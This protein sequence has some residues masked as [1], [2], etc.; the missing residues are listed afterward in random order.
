MHYATGAGP[1][2]GVHLIFVTKDL[3]Q[4]VHEHPPIGP[5]GRITQTLSF[6][7]SGAWQV[8]IDAYLPGSATTLVNRNF[9]L[10]Q[11]VTVTGHHTPEPLGPVRRSVTS[12][13]YRFTIEHLPEL[14][15]A[16]AQFMDVA[17]RSQS[18]A[19][20]VFTPWFG[21]LAHAIFFQPHAPWDYDFHTH[22]CSPDLALCTVKG[23]I[24]GSS[25][26]HG[27]L[28]VGMLFPTAG[29]WRLFLQCKIDGTV[30]TAPFTL[31]VRS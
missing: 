1:H 30:I 17:V 29:R 9:Q 5:D 4:I 24:S 23:T 22:I 16:Q 21:A 10:H 28:R 19:T 26:Q 2:V 11:A 20:P 13:G 8:L 14:H 27:D 25:P 6:P 31:D 15:V 7:A 3:S 12:D 18:G